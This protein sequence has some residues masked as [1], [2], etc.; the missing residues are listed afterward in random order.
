M[1]Y[2]VLA[3]VI[4]VRATHA[5]FDQSVSTIAPQR[6]I[7]VLPFQ[8]NNLLCEG[9]SFPF[10]KN[11]GEFGKC[12]GISETRL[13]AS[14]GHWYETRHR[15]LHQAPLRSSERRRFSFII[16]PPGR[17]Y[18]SSATIRCALCR[19]CYLTSSRQAERLI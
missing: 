4:S 19:A 13:G 9:E 16:F 7:E 3:S 1:V 17:L 10:Q 2:E 5:P 18:P 14:S 6:L 15:V 12:L 8:V 11:I